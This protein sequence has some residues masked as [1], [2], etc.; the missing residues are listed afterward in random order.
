MPLNTGIYYEDTAQ[1]PQ[2]NFVSSIDTEL[3]YCFIEFTLIFEQKPAIYSHNDSA[4][5]EGSF[6]YGGLL[7][8][9]QLKNGIGSV[10]APYKDVQSLF[11]V[12]ISN[13]NYISTIPA[14]LLCE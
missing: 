12:E 14:M 6:I 4:G 5:K 8:R 2:C 11:N 9:C 10:I 13:N 1:T 7:D 3:P